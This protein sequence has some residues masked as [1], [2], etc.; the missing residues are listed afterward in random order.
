ME[1]LQLSD[2]SFSATINN[3]EIRNIQLASCAGFTQ[4]EKKLL[5]HL[6]DK[7]L[8]N[9]MLLQ[10]IKQGHLFVGG[11]TIFAWSRVRFKISRGFIF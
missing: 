3:V 9:N 1:H 6:D 11:L 7:L 8:E 10:Q 5:Q 2:Y 4:L